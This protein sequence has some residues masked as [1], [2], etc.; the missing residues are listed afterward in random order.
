MLDESQTSQ[1]GDLQL[2]VQGHASGVVTPLHRLAIT[3]NGKG[4]DQTE[5]FR[6]QGNSLDCYV[7]EID[8]KEMAEATFHLQIKGTSVGTFKL[9]L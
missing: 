7:Y 1:R 9:K 3:D 6:Y 8:G 2:L 5:Y 4:I